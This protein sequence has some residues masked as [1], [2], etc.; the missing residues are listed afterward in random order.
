MNRAQETFETT[1]KKS[2]SSRC[3]KTGSRA[4]ELDLIEDNG[5]WCDKFKEG[6]K[7]K[8]TIKLISRKKAA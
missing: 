2:D 1:M 3:E 4:I 8:V 5:C 6:D 7:V